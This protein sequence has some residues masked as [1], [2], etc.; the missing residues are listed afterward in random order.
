MRLAA[1]ALGCVVAMGGVA[2]ARSARWTPQ[3]FEAPTA[4]SDA[5]LGAL[6]RATGDGDPAYAQRT[7]SLTFLVAGKSLDA[8]LVV[9]GDDFRFTTTIDG[10]SYASG[11]SAGVRWRRT[12]TGVVHTI[13][14]DTQGDDLDRWPLALFAI[15]AR[16]AEVVGSVRG[17]SAANVVVERSPTDS[18][19]W[20]FVD[21]ATGDIVREVA[22]EGSRTV[23]T[24][25]ADFRSIGTMRRA[26]GWHISGAGG[27]ADV[28]VNDV[29]E[30]PV[31]AADV[32]IPEPGTPAFAGTGAIG[33]G[34]LPAAFAGF[35]V[36]LDARVDGRPARLLLDTG[37]PQIVLDASF[38]RGLHHAATLGHATVDRIEVGG[39][40]AR[41]VAVAALPLGGYGVDGILGYDFFLGNVVHVD[42]GKHRVDWIARDAFVP[43]VTMHELDAPAREGMPIVAV[44]LR[45]TVARRFVLDTG[46]FSIV[47][48]RRLLESVAGAEELGISR[49]AGAIVAQPYL[50]G[51]I[52]TRLQ[53]VRSLRLANFDFRDVPAQ[54]EVPDL[55]DA[56]VFPID[57]ILGT[58]L[59]G[60]YAWWFDESAGRVWFS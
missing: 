56:V 16:S 3:V 48:M 43:D 44:G 38:A 1:F 20:F 31:D 21:S 19:H 49:E 5:I 12:P 35:R 7:E 28:R 27:D 11:R 58:E 25:F 42:Y 2:S 53:T 29:R 36:V 24:R 30:G 18:P 26:F 55:A 15:D 23:V 22:R 17:P 51:A 40:A 13:S 60:S 46:S 32:A 33:G 37:T 10:E 6:A 14:A 4:A 41:H 50:E 34:D 45:D 54:V 47:L 9:R 8:T 57:G 39:L 59:L 52:L